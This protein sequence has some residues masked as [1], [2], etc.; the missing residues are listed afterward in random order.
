MIID[1]K[2]DILR[3][4]GEP[5]QSKEW[6][7]YLVYG[8]G[9]DDVPNLLDIV[10]DQTPNDAD[11]NSA[12]IWASLHAWRTLG[13]LRCS[14]AIEPLINLFDRFNQND[15]ALTELPMVIGMIGNA[16]IE[17]LNRYLNSPSHDSFSRVMALESMEEIGLRHLDSR[18]TVV[19]VMTTYLK[20]PDQDDPFLNA[21]VVAGLLDFSA[22]E[23]IDT[24]REV[25]AKGLA[26]LSVCGDIEEIEISLGL[27]S[28]RSTPKPDYHPD[29]P[30]EELPRL[31][32][33]ESDQIIG[34][35]LMKY[36]EDASIQGIS[37][38][39]G[40][41]TAIASSPK[42]IMPSVWFPAIW[43]SGD[44]APEWDDMNEIKQ[45]SSAVMDHYNEALNL[46]RNTQYQALFIERQINGKGVLVVNDWCEGYLRGLQFW[47]TLDKQEQHF[48]EEQTSGIQ[49]FGTDEGIDQL[50][51]MSEIEIEF[52]QQAIDPVVQ[53]VFDHFNSERKKY[54]TI[55]REGAKIGRNDPCPCGSG[56]KFKKCCLH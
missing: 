34:F 27:R 41:L 45:F 13:Q 3:K 33:D 10:T 46:L 18:E 11:E 14:E 56:K 31:Y 53:N 36:G 26:E 16:G 1:S 22:V 4:L 55:E 28:E 8:F 5:D 12:E 9:C 2:F 42:L 49:L 21:C 17:P 32:E 48:L 20:S 6:A 47:P 50:D 54:T 43:G 30:F 37:E 52:L 24:I 35:C 39:H 19:S 23:S 44:Q 40:Y 25:Y 29:F 15:W 51:A 7:D 38:L